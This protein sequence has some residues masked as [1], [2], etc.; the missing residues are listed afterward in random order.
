MVSFWLSFAGIKKK[1]PTNV[2][3]VLKAGIEP[4]RLATL[5]FESNV[6]TNSTTWA[7][8][9]ESRKYRNFSLPIPDFQ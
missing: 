3:F 8:Y 5:D 9:L 2:G 1:K 6:S 7:I 4:A